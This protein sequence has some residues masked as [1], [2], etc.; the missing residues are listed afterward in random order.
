MT[1]RRWITAAV[2]AA[3]LAT[4]GT[5]ASAFTILT[6]FTNSCHEG[7]TL[8]A[9][10]QSGV[11][12][13]TVDIVLPRDDDDEWDRL[14]TFLFNELDIE[15][16]DPKA[17]YFLFSLLAGVRSPDTDGHSA[18]NLLSLRRVQGDPEGQYA[19]CLRAVDDDGS[20]GDRRAHAACVGFITG[21]VQKAVEL[22]LMPPA[23][24]NI[25]R[26]FT[27]E[28]YGQAEVEVWGPIF[29]VGRASHALQDSFTHT[30]RSDD[31]RTIFSMMNYAEAV[32]A[33]LEE[34]RD[35]IA[36]STH[37]DRCDDG[38]RE[39]PA[40]SVDATADLL[41]AGSSWIRT[42]NGQSF[43]AFVAKWLD[44]R[45]GCDLSNQYCDSSWLERARID[46]TGPFV[47][48][49]ATS[50][51]SGGG[52]LSLYLIAVVLLL[53]RRGRHWQRAHET[54]SLR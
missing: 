9:Y 7:I 33:S 41:R 8:T 47:D 16:E 46:P 3:V 14:A 37:A 44:Y 19:H 10:E 17:R 26:I 28:F 29:Y 42:G 38:I 48:C 40:A 45:E 1:K 18:L 34:S 51:G 35:G 31:L 4:F 5:T 20:E 53:R 52:A 50:S 54:E 13:E 36:H 30:I 32:G 24:Q 21:E 43:D 22:L 39:V 6:G 2:I 11:D 27:L 25:E 12:L 15:I 23:E 49:S